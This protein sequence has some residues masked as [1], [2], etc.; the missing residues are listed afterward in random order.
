MISI[1]IKLYSPGFAR[2]KISTASFP[3][4]AQRTS[5]FSFSNINCAISIFNSLSSTRS[6][7]FPFSETFSTDDSGIIDSLSEE[8][9]NGNV[10]TNEVPSSTLLVKQICPPISFTNWLTIVIPRPVPIFAF[11][12][13]LF[14]CVKGSNKCSWNSSLI[15]I[16]LS[17]QVNSNTAV[18]S[19]E[20]ISWQ[21]T[22]ILPPTWL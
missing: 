20:L 10:I 19:S 12:S 5:M 16:P 11:C 7:L 6:A 15:P 3:F 8:I 9:W 21:P 17:V 1:N 13:S 18:R 4:H 2:A 22:I 14:S